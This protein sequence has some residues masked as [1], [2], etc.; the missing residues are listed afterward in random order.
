MDR[1]RRTDG[2]QPSDTVFQRLWDLEKRI[3][4]K[5]QDD[6]AC[7]KKEE[8]DLMSDSSSS[9][10]E[11]EDEDLK[12]EHAEKEEDLDECVASLEL[13]DVVCGVCLRKGCNVRSCPYRY[14][15]PPGVHEV[16]EGYEI[17]CRKCIR[18]DNRC[19]H[20]GM[21]YV[22]PAFKSPWRRAALK[23]MAE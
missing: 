15:V 9:S 21:G 18:L 7:E 23:P 8:K 17:A 4:A 13:E 16:G 20:P 1:R 12:E 2:N 11:E 6:D 5:Q 14:R 3:L 22:R 19:R 10:S